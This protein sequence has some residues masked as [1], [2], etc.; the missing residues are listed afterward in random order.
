MKAFK[1]FTFVMLFLVVVSTVFAQAFVL[2]NRFAGF[3]GQANLPVVSSTRA[4]FRIDSVKV[5]DLEM[6]GSTPVYVQRGTVVPVEVQFMGTN[7]DAYDTRIRVYIGGYEY[8]DVQAASDI[9]EVIPG[10]RDSRTLRLNVPYDLESSDTYTLNVEMYDDDNSIRKT[11]KLRVEETRNLVSVFDVSFNPS[12]NVQAGTP[13]FATVRVENLGDNIE[14]TV[15]VTLSIPALNLQTSQYVDR[16]VTQQDLNSDDSGSRRTAASTN[17]LALVLPENTPEGDYQVVVRTEYNR[18]HDFKEKTYVIHVKGTAA[19]VVQP[20]T[21][22]LSIN[23]DTTAQKVVSGQ[24]AQ[25]KFSVSNMGQNPS[26]LSFEVLG[27]SDWAAFRVDPQ[28]VTVPANSAKDVNVFVAPAEN[29]EGAKTF[30]VRVKDANNNV[31]AEKTL[32]LEVANNASQADTLKKVL[33]V[34][35]VVL[36]GILVLLGIVLVIKKL[37]QDSEDKPVEGQTYY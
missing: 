15:K 33:A 31:V 13:L 1:I 7:K 28:S 35:F 2:P 14:D 29:F 8:G 9:F 36:L 24:G 32:S 10:V 3:A 26:T 27:A 20:V 17:E 22:P 11:F 12:D 6:S 30:T 21:N 18:L 16:L 34:G 37:T 23:V 19:A 4:D 5:N 25:Y